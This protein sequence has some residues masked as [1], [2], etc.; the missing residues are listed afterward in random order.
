MEL[1][2]TKEIEVAVSNISTQAMAMTVTDMASYQSAGQVLLAF[3]DME[4]NIK[5]YFKPLKDSAHKTWK[6]IC[7]RENEELAKLSPGVTHLNKTMIAYKIE[8]DRKHREEEEILRQAAMNA[9]EERR[10]AD[11]L[12]AEKEGK[13]AEAELILE[14]PIFVPPPIVET[15][16]PKIDGLGVQTIWKWRITNEALIPRQYMQVD[17]V[18]IN[19]VVRSLKDKTDI[20]GI[21]VYSEQSMKKVRGGK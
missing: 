21:I 6:S 12:H 8:E 10:L 17:E 5:V 7:D 20:P 18:K 9:E 2:D 1:I 16:A 4:K 11:A 14:T 15:Q 3:K 13:K 19:G